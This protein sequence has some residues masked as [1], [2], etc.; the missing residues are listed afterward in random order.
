MKIFTRYMALRF[1]GPFFVGLGMFALLIFLGDMFDKMGT[2]VK[3]Q[4]HLGT[5][6]QYLWL[7]VPYWT[8]RVIPMATLLATLMALTG[9]VQSGEWI[10]V[11]SCGF[12][13]KDFWK[14]ILYCS[15]AVTAL[16]FA[17]QESVL[18]MCYR[19]ARQLWQ[20]QIHPEWEWDQYSDIALI[21]APGQFIQAK[22]FKPKE[23]RMDRPVLERLGPSG[24][25]SQLDAKSALWNQGTG[26]WD[27]HDGVERRF[28]AGRVEERVFSNEESDLTVPPRNLIPR[29]RN[30][31]EMSLREIRSYAERVQHLG[32]SARELR[33]A[34][35][36]KVA[37]PFTNF[38]ICAL[39]IPVALKLRRAGKAVTF[40]AALALSFL[41]LWVSELGRAL[42]NS[43]TL[44]PGVAAW[45][46]NAIFGVAAA[47]GITRSEI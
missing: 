4:A 43:G 23:G 19:R 35:Q 11:Q 25:E 32:V 47:V 22:L 37:Y 24:V 27:F 6:V 12:E 5:I 9:F 38:V 10:A 34:E 2:L 41:F 18:P 33:V 40:F 15:I 3:S 20:D 44:S 1:A 17:A 42:G 8:I 46:A 28:N 26:R 14:P 39:G 31:D 21:G 16:S 7:E 36:N 30:P 29:T 13:T 45:A